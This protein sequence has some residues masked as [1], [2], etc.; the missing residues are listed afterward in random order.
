MVFVCACR[1]PGDC[2]SLVLVWSLPLLLSKDFQSGMV[3]DGFLTQRRGS[4][5]KNV[6]KKSWRVWSRLMDG[7]SGRV[8]SAR[9]RMCRQGGIAGAVIMTS[10]QVCEGSTGK[11]SSQG[12]E[13][14]LRAPQHRVERKKGG[15][16]AWR[17]RMRSLEPG[18]RPCKRRKAKESKEGRG[19]HEGE[20][21]AWKKSGVWRWTSSR[22]KLDEQKKKLHEE[23]R[24]I[25]FSCV[26]K[27]FQESLKSNMHQQLQEVEQR[28]HDFMPER[29][30]VQK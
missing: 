14:G 18:L 10:Q 12:M 28:R 3:S 11:R 7:R 23:L 17:Q 20:K 4:R 26:P 1:D 15:A 6:Q 24:D 19:F 9:S 16:R 30:K 29:Q 21:A 13:N 25:K 2:L 8:N 5:V 27:E 22:K